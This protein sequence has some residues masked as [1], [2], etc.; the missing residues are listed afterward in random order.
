M[1]DRPIIFSAPMVRALLAGRKTQTRRIVTETTLPHLQHPHDI[2]VTEGAGLLTRTY[3]FRRSFA[4]G[5]RLWV[6]EAHAIV[7]RTAYRCSEGVAQV[8]RPDDDHDAAIFRCGWDRSAPRWRPGIHMPRWASR[9][10]LTVAEVRIERLQEISE[11][12]AIAEGCVPD[13]ASLNPNHIGPARSIFE[14]LWDSLNAER[15]Y[16][17]DANPWVVA[18]TF[19]FEQRNIDE[20]AR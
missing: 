5:D 8:L 15:G 10:T 6:R 1:T 11:V 7:P 19:A 14:G 2:H 4:A 12:D 13:D 9:I 3:R 18:V 16:G 17:W 20:A